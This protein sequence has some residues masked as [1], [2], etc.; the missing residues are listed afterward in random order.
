MPPVA[1]STLEGLLEHP[2]QAFEAYRNEGVDA[3][4]CEE[5]HMGSRAVVVL[6]RDRTAALRR[7]GA[8]GDA[9]GA[10]YTRTGRPFFDA[11]LTEEMLAR[12]RAAA[13]TAGAF[14]ELATD[15]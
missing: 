14:D 10:V 5:K 12:L 1:T 7:F 15:W 6:P 11:A 8:P 4:V 9:S 13:E 2:E 3:V